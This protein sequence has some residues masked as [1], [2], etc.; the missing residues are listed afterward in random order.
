MIRVSFDYDYSMVTGSISLLSNRK[1]LHS[2]VTSK[3]THRETTNTL[4]SKRFILFIDVVLL[5]LLG[6]NYDYF[7]NNTKF[8]SIT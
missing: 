4:L 3:I 5:K 1:Q 8:Y 2:W 7:F 6:Y